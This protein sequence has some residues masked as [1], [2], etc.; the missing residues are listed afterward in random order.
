MPI[1]HISRHPFNSCLSAY[2]SNFGSGHRY[3]SSLESTAQHYKLMMDMLL[4]Y[5][6][7]GVNFLEIHYEDLV[8]DQETITREILEYIGAPWDDAC[9]Q[10]HKSSR[11]VKTASYEQV[12][13]KI[14]TSSLYRYRNYH[15]AVKPL[16][17]ILEATLAQFG[18]T[19]E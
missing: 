7:I 10:H 6:S 4:H 17:P 3:T 13:R 8:Q 19:A 5:R 1:I 12:T 15:Q 2:F 16:T 9:L 11:V 18:Y 14:Y